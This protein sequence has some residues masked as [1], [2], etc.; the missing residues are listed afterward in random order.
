MSS[1]SHINL[2]FQHEHRLSVASRRNLTI[3]DSLAYE[4]TVLPT[5][6]FDEEQYMRDSKKYMLGR[7]LKEKVEILVTPSPAEE[8]V[9]DGGWLLHQIP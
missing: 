2:D 3:S 7:Y 8:I 5:S 1:C 4:L 9:I 6:M